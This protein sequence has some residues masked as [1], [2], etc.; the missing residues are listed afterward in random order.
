MLTAAQALMPG[1]YRWW[2]GAVSSNGLITVWSAPKT[3]TIAP[4]LTSPAHNSTGAGPTP[5]FTWSFSATLTVRYEFLL[6]RVNTNGSTTQV[7][8]NV[9]VTSTSYTP[10][11]TLTSAQKYRWWVRAYVNGT[12]G[13]WSLGFDFF[14]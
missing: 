4:T 9:N 11:T 7:H 1:H 3:F 5:T 2:I 13:A 14:A 8:Q 10:P 12:P 6:V